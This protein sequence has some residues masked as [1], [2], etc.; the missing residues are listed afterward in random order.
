MK[1]LILAGGGGTRLWP[2]SR[3]N[4]PKQI[5]P[6][7]GEK[8]LLQSTHDRVRR[9]FGEE[10]V[11]LSTNASLRDSILA[12]L[13]N[14]SERRLFLEPQKK[15][16]AAAIG[17]AAVMIAREDPDAIFVT[18]NSD[19]HIGNEEKYLQ[20][21]RLAERV[22]LER[23]D[24]TVLVG[25]NPTYPETGYGYIEM[26]REAMQMDGS[27]VFEAKRFVEKPNPEKAKEYLSR[28]EY[29]W[30]PAMFVWRVSTLLALYE[31]FLPEMF[32]ELVRIRN[33]SENE[34]SAIIES[35]FENMKPISID[36]GIMEKIEEK[37]LVIPADF[38]WADVGHW[39]TVGEVLAK[40]EKENVVKGRHIGVESEGNL[41]YSYGEKLIATCGVKDMII[42]DTGDALLVCAKDKAQEVKRIVGEIEKRDW[43]EL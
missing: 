42:I 17:F 25:V 30:N 34:L 41:I 20:T 32:R 4:K 16:T 8:T 6:L 27:R 15:D 3:K 10:D 37:M 26:G 18:V 12:Q 7:I 13:P 21:L 2:V 39:R 23:P 1:A 28:W 5:H 33:A 14:F 35:A 38:G 22:V 9:G 19:A 29:L 11:Y 31:K 40:N 36:Y 43:K 24:H